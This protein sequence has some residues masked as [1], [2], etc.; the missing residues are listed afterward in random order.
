MLSSV[1]PPRRVAEPRFL[2]V[3][4]KPSQPWPSLSVVPKRAQPW[5][6][7]SVVPLSFVPKCGQ[8]LPVIRPVRQ[9]LPPFFCLVAGLVLAVP[10]IALAQQVPSTV[11]TIEHIV[12]VVD[13]R[14]LLLSDVRAMERVRG[15]AEEAAL[16]ALVDERLMYLEASRLPQADVLAEEEERAAGEI[17]ERRPSLRELVSAEDLRRIVGRQ[18]AILKYVEFRFRPQLRVSDQDVRAAFEA[19]PS[20][21][22]SWEAAKQ[23]VRER[24][25][26][27][28]L[29]ERIEAWVRELRARADVR[30]VGRAAAADTP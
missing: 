22:D 13:G 11:T 24:L 30:Y 21:G 1:A 26:R 27:R 15:L 29:D 3:V 19:D 12:A 23:R 8:L 17:L 2:S 16:E 10:Q 9:S 25:E 18:I 5:P 4:R 14:P 20:A 28:A 7:L 6:F